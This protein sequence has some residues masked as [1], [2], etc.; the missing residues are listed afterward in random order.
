MR[1]REVVDRLDRAVVDLGGDPG[2]D[3]SIEDRLRDLERAIARAET[4]L[5]TV[6]ADRVRLADG[7][8]QLAVGVV[9]VADGAIV[10]RNDVARQFA[11]GRTADVLVEAAIE[12]LLAAVRDGERLR[13]TLR[14][15]GPPRRTLELDGRPTASGDTI[16]IIRDVSAHE[17]LD[18]V[19]RDFVANISHEL[20]TPI[21]ALTLLAETL[22]G[23]TDPEIVERLSGRVL[24]EAHR[25][26]N[27][28][29]DLLELS[30]VEVGEAHDQSP[31]SVQDLVDEATDLVRSAAE[32]RS[33]R[34][35]V[36]VDRQLVVRGDRRQLVSAL[37]N[38]LDNAIRYTD[39]GGGVAVRARLEGEDAEVSVID[40]GIGIPTRDLDRVFERFYRVDRARSRDRGGT[41]LGLSIVR[42]V[43]DNHG[44]TSAMSSVEG[45]G[46]TVTL[47]LPGMR[48]AE[49]RGDG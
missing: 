10:H 28:V 7:L 12:D 1:R 6:S 5:A 36:E 41:G 31:L 35:D 21:G 42:H 18:Q 9:I 48:I 16:V 27:I 3:G 26:A 39:G 24:T 14:L 8:D 2:V 19:R 49:A 37:V 15:M 17:R 30:R 22:E 32:D 4:E 13:K 47:R 11:S 46:T 23:E 25:A 45:Q 20:K 38:V 40:Q 29:E 34:V 43:M 33:V 44:G